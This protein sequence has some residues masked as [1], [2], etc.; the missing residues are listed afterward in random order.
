MA[1]NPVD[2]LGFGQCARLSGYF[3]TRFEQNQRGNAANAEL[4]GDIL[5][6]IG[7]ELGH[8]DI[9]FKC[10]RDAGKCRCHRL[11]GAAPGRPEVD[12]ER[13]VGA[14]HMPIEI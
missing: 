12:Y 2:Q 5:S 3:P 6:L 7:I 8:S 11:T 14:G 4:R 13:N 9:G 10:L 1:G